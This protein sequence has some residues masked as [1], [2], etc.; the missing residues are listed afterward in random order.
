MIP[1]LDLRA[2][3]D[4]HREAYDAAYRT[5]MDAGRFILDKQVDS[6]E[7]A[8]AAYCGVKH[9][10]GVGSGYDALFLI[11]K[12]MDIGPGDEV[13]VPAHTFFATW[14]AVSATRATPVGVD[15]RA[16]SF[17]MDPEEAARRITAKAR[18]V[19]PVHLYGLPAAMTPLRELCTEHG[20]EL[21]E[22][23]A[24]AQGAYY[25]DRRVGSLGDAAG[26]SFYPVKNLGAL[27]D[28]GCVTTD[29]DRLAARIRRLR[30]Y[31]SEQKYRHLEP[32]VNSRLDELQAAFLSVGLKHLDA[33]NDR[34]REIAEL[35]DHGLRG[36]LTLPPADP[37]SVRHQYVVRH[38]QRDRLAA[39]LADR[40]IGTI[41]HYPEP[42]FLQ[43]PY[44]DAVTEDFPVART[45]CETCLS[46]PI[47]PFLTDEQAGTVI[48]AIL[49]FS[50]R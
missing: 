16:D 31:G 34:R 39:F 11:L 30:N 6:F 3:L 27:G 9:C 12:A 5:V 10:I 47:H 24:Q 14:S 41:I 42:P 2:Q 21:I 19:M 4:A 46:L 17:N 38:P 43:P 18:A 49:S 29:D 1:F 23:A 28:A 32:G 33:W 45:V 44:A 8:Y 26:F 20:L 7:R 36:K 50:N 40:G 22:D 35:Y 15:V 25:G 48:D 37:S 13:L